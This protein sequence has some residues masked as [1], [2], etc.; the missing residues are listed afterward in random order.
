MFLKYLFNVKLIKF[1]K[2][3]PRNGEQKNDFTEMGR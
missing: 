3:E 1:K 2:S